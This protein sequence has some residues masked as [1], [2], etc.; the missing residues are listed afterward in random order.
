MIVTITL[1]PAI[2]K[3][4]ELCD[5]NI[6]ALDEVDHWIE[7]PA[8][9]GINV[10]KV[11]ESFGGESIATGF[12]GGSAG[13]YIENALKELGIANDF[14]HISDMTRTNLKI[15]DNQ[16]KKTRE[17]NEP[18]PFVSK[19]DIEL[20]I[21]KVDA[22]I[23]LPCVVVISG[24]APKSI[25]DDIYE[26]LVKAAK[27]KGAK[28]F[29][30]ASGTAFKAGLKGIPDFIK[31][32]KHEVEIYFGNSIETDEDL[33]AAGQHFLD[34]G[35]R[36]V[37]ITLGKKGAFYA[38][39]EKSLMLRPLRVNACSSV[40]AGDAFVGA[41]VYAYDHEYEVEEMLKLAVATSAGA[42]MTIGTKPM[43]AEWIMSQIDRVVIDYI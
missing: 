10:S 33:K 5:D 14:V 26:T 19:T 28:V 4:I 9:K 41:F 8:G 39:K 24:S 37:F 21:E 16:T 38:N 1:N 40:G 11:V 43:N 29:L 36:H 35:I 18:G 13:L 25:P 42:V 6:N 2:D 27:N 17:I 34:M 30:D 3:T 31:P 20:L 12:L 22:L 32:N 7:D 15:F 23:K